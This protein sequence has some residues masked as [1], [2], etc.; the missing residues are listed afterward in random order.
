MNKK[1][2]Q[3]LVLVVFLITVGFIYLK[4]FSSN[5]GNVD[6]RK[7]LYIRTGQTYAQVVQTLKD[8]QMVN[9]LGAF[10]WVGGL[11]KLKSNIHPG[12]YEIS[13][14]MGNYAIVNMLKSGRQKPVKLVLN[15]LRTK[16]DIIKKLSSQLEAD[17]VELNR[18]FSD[19]NFLSTWNIDTNQVQCLI[20]PATYELYWNTPA[21]KVVEK[22]A[23]AHENFWTAD[24]R[25]QAKLLNLSIPQVITIASIVEEETNKN[26]EKANIASVYL[27]RYKIGMKLG[28]DPTVKY[29]VGDFGLRRILNVHTQ[30]PSPYNTYYAIGIPPGPIC[31]P[32]A[33]S[34]EAVLLPASTSYLF[35]CAKEDFSGYHNFA[36]TYAE[37]LANAKKYQNA[38]NQ[39][40]IK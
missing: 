32:S 16:R 38:L 8:S 22:I 6:E 37:H 39:R 29:A 5:T 35:F 26:D 9:N 18:L 34:I 27:N 3:L 12:R 2:L 17:S 10:E 31:T 15:K 28:A 23:K 33:K 1:S 20:M 4:L 40:G 30:F 14:G 24:R 7:Y 25:S 11:F 13:K 19:P 36:T 21:Q